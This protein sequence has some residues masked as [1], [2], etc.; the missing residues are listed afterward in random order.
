MITNLYQNLLHRA[1]S[2]AEVTAGLG[3]V[4]GSGLFGLFSGLFTAAEFR[5]TGAFA[6]SSATTDHS[7]SMF[8]TMIYFAVLAR[9]PDTSGYNFWVGVANSGGAGI[10]FQPL[11]S[12]GA[13]MRFQVEGP[14]VA[15]Q[16]LV[17]SPEFQNLFA[18]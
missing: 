1:P 8:V 15:G 5:N 4:S 17:G 7:N 12:T 16:G 18:N 6:S 9:D 14:G 13:N 2:G 10:Y 11:G 3:T